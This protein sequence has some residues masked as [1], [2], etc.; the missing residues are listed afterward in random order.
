MSEYVELDGFQL[1]A[2][3]LGLRLSVSSHLFI[4]NHAN[5][6]LDCHG[7]YECVQAERLWFLP[8]SIFYLQLKVQVGDRAM[9]TVLPESNFLEYCANMICLATLWDQLGLSISC[10]AVH[11]ETDSEDDPNLF[12]EIEQPDKS[13]ALL[14]PPSVQTSTVH[15]LT[16]S[17]DYDWTFAQSQEVIVFDNSTNQDPEEYLDPD[18][19]WL[20]QQDD[21]WS[22]LHTE[23]RS[24]GNDPSEPFA[25]NEDI[26]KDE[27]SS[28]EYRHTV[29]QL[30]LAS[31]HKLIGVKRRFSGIRVGDPI[32]PTLLEL[33]PCVC[34][35]SYIQTV[36]KYANHFPAIADIITDASTWRPSLRDKIVKI[37]AERSSDH[38]RPL[39]SHHND[40]RYSIRQRLW[41]L[42]RT[43]LDGNTGMRHALSRVNRSSRQLELQHPES[44]YFEY[45]IN[46]SDENET[47][48]SMDVVE[49]QEWNQSDCYASPDTFSWASNSRYGDRVLPANSATYFNH[50]NQLEP[51]NGPVIYGI[52]EPLQHHAQNGD[53][54]IDDGIIHRPAYQVDTELNFDDTSRVAFTPYEQRKSHETHNLAPRSH[55]E[56]T[57]ED[58]DEQWDDTECE[59]YELSQ[60]F[61][62]TYET[63]AYPAA[64]LT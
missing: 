9:H 12:F 36:A 28:A 31:L 46:Q 24:A 64:P 54:M 19:N 18:K 13:F 33:A 2:P 45:A 61:E 42:L 1:L 51:E 60:E 32:S 50:E 62:A 47:E 21:S 57:E 29:V 40:T 16:C 38:E 20:Y 15:G 25:I 3:N 17:L 10:T 23:D 53:T 6:E 55:I 48:D 43:S 35:A 4:S 41:T 49:H 56:Y 27:N 8:P 52:F 44:L 26:T 63:A 39:D 37:S 7:L 22:D 34:N 11:Y 59:H 14:S 5:L 58:G 30:A